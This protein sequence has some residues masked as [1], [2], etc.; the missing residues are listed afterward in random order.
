MDFEEVVINKLIRKSLFVEHVMHMMCECVRHE[1]PHVMYKCVTHYAPV[2]CVNEV[3]L[4]LV[5]SMATLGE[6]QSHSPCVPSEITSCSPFW[7]TVT[8][9][10]A[11]LSLSTAPRRSLP[12]TGSLSYNVGHHNQSCQRHLKRAHKCGHNDHPAPSILILRLSYLRDSPKPKMAPHTKTC[13]PSTS[14][15][16]AQGITGRKSSRWM[17]TQGLEAEMLWCPS[18]TLLGQW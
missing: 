16:E 17:P 1:G 18:P 15:K 10:R 4:R 12:S 5:P 2:L 6:A 8:F 7:T 14:W 13:V 11:W 9:P 3:F